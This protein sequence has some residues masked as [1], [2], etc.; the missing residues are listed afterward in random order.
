MYLRSRSSH[1]VNLSIPK[2]R[3]LSNILKK[4][5]FRSGTWMVYHSPNFGYRISSVSLL[6]WQIFTHCCCPIVE[7]MCVCV[8][9]PDNACVCHQ[10]KFFSK[11]ETSGN[12]LKKYIK[13]MLLLLPLSHINIRVC[14]QRNVVGSKYKLIEKCL[15]RTLAGKNLNV[16][17]EGRS[18]RII[19]EKTW[20]WK[21]KFI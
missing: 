6:S 4:N 16:H 21:L 15:S 10:D 1:K 11:S 9:V 5:K 13:E 17:R 14:G 18:D 3:K 20:R 8:C 7:P 2:H 12:P 19:D